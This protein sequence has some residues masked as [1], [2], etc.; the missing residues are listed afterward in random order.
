LQLPSRSRA[1][2][3]DHLSQLTFEGDHAR[4]PVFCLMA[5]VNKY[6][7]L[8][9]TLGANWNYRDE[10]LCK[11]ISLDV[12][13]HCDFHLR[14]VVGHCRPPRVLLARDKSTP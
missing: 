12:R 5:A 1:A 13:N 14:L 10:P 8:G 7:R 9:S 6:S 3:L 4:L 11:G 2:P